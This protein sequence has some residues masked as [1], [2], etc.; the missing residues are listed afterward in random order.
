MTNP[1][2]TAAMIDDEL[3]QSYRLAGSNRYDEMLGP[4]GKV[5]AHWRGLL[6]ELWSLSDSERLTRAAR[7]DRRVRETGIAYDIFSDP[8]K[9][10]Q[11]WQLDLAPVVF[12]SAEWRWLEAALIQRARLFDALLA[13]IYG[14]QR[15]MREDLVPPELIFSDNS[16][17]RP[18][19]KI[20]PQAGGLQF[21]AADLARG[22][23]GLWRI[24]DNH[25]EVEQVRRKI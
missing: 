23:D 20:L 21:Y 13:D 18:C 6:S 12:S 22:A 10:S 9:A 3:L 4:D 16:Y 19:Q 8:N 14:E 2:P 25:T 11:R 5:R 15:L 17:L 24:I 7:M 1:A